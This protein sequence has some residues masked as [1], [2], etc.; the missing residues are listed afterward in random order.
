MRHRNNDSHLFRDSRSN[1]IKLLFIHH[2]RERINGTGNRK[3]P[4]ASC[5]MNSLLYY[6]VFRDVGCK[7]RGRKLKDFKFQV[8]SMYV[9]AGIERRVDRLWLNLSR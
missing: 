7:L 5:L 8:L 1:T 2:A 3:A 9:T 6:L 4:V